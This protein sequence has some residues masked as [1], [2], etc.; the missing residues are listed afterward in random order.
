VAQF[1]IYMTWPFIWVLVIAM[2]MVINPNFWG[3]L[4]G[5]YS[6]APVN[7][8]VYIAL[9]YVF[10]RIA[11]RVFLYLYAKKQAKRLEEGGKKSK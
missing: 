9:A 4:W 1:V 3:D 8:I 11:K 10:W 5:W 2:G 7:N 6:S